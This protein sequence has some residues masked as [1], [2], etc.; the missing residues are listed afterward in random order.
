MKFFSFLHVDPTPKSIRRRR[1]EQ[2]ICV[3]NA[4]KK[5]QNFLT[6]NFFAKSTCL[7][8]ET[9]CW[10][11]KIQ[12]LRRNIQKA[13]FGNFSWNLKK[14]GEFSLKK[15]KI[16]KNFPKS[17]KIFFSYENEFA[18]DHFIFTRKIKIRKRERKCKRKRKKM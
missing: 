2:K 5:N 14:F 8:P 13:T 9:L 11:G 15:K 6:E 10:N 17:Q 12:R 1:K 18:F 4:A 16:S 7:Y 3:A